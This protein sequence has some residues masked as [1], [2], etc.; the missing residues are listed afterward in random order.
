MRRRNKNQ[1]ETAQWASLLVDVQVG[2]IGVSGF[3]QTLAGLF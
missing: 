1:T 2:R 3:G